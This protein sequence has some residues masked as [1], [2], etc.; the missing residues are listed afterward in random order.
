MRTLL[1]KAMQIRERG[2][3]RAFYI[4]LNNL[5]PEDRLKFAQEIQ[6]SI[7]EIEKAFMEFA[8][9]M[10]SMI[11]QINQH[12]KDINFTERWD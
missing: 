6:D 1:G 12:L 9:E 4:W 10:E 5:S 7:R 2:G 11:E 3:D 8:S